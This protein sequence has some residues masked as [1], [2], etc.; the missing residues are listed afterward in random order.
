[1]LAD[2]EAVAKDIGYRIDAWVDN[3]IIVNTFAKIS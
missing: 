1:M 3:L 2:L